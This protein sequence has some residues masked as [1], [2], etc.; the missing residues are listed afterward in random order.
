MF[1]LLVKR[2]EDAEE[3]YIDTFEYLATL[4]VLGAVP[5]DEA[6][7]L[8]DEV[9]LAALYRTRTNDRAWLSAALAAG[10]TRREASR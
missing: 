2:T 10:V 7:E 5:A 6:A 1:P 3:A 4:P 9:L 8:I